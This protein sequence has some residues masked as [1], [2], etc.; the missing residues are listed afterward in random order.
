[1][2][3]RLCT[4]DDVAA[5]PQLIALLQDAVHGGASVGFL[6]PLTDE[7][8]EAY[9][10]RVLSSVGEDLYLWV[11]ETDGQIVGSVQLELSTKENGTHRA[12]IQKLFVLTSYRGRGISSNLMKTAESKGA[13]LG[14]S[15]LFLD[16]QAGSTA[17]SVYRHLGWTAAGQI[18]DYAASPDGKLHATAYF[19]K[20]TRAE[21]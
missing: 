10:R 13:S 7:R 5:I 9:W 14:R 16:T 18:P 3:T 20:R 8:A 6:S 11:Y 17:A 19:Y 4:N 2:T 15:L 21:A 12:E 1:M